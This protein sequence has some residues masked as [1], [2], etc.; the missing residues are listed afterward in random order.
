[1]LHHKQESP[2][3]SEI[4]SLWN[5]LINKLFL[6]EYFTEEDIDKTYEMTM[7]TIANAA[8]VS[9]EFRIHICKNATLMD[10]I[11]NPKKHASNLYLTHADIL[12]S[13]L[14]TQETHLP[15]IQMGILK[16]FK[17]FLFDKQ[18]TIREEGAG[19]LLIISTCF[20]AIPF[21]TE[22]S[23]LNVI[24]KIL[25]RND[26][27]KVVIPIKFLFCNLLIYKEA[28]PKMTHM[29]KYLDTILY[30]KYDNDLLLVCLKGI[31]NFCKHNDEKLMQ[32]ALE[33]FDGITQIEKISLTHSDQ[34]ISSLAIKILNTFNQEMDLSE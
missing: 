25:I 12:T 33:E 30:E 10:R 26:I 2:N 1:M 7:C 21:L 11:I 27:R 19:G 34:E 14:L 3:V 18:P 24:E 5:I 6:N 23:F 32:N 8:K 17:S 28:L 31:L 15:L 4:M 20:A 22:E 13:L 29:L 16:L 9:D